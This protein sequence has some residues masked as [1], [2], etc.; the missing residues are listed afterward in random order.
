MNGTRPELLWP[1]SG[2]GGRVDCTK[3]VGMRCTDTTIPDA[4]ASDGPRDT[5]RF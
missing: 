1:F 3:P 5:G 4:A 2:T